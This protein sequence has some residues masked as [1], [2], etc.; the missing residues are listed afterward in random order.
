MRVTSP[1]VARHKINHSKESDM[2]KNDNGH[3]IVLGCNYHTAWQRYKSMRFVLKSINTDNNTAIMITRKTKK[4]FTTNINDL[5][6][7]DSSTNRYKADRLLKSDEDGRYLK[8]LL[9]QG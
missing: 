5:V 3:P 8:A 1:E 4:E 6:F 9:I 2:L 7:I